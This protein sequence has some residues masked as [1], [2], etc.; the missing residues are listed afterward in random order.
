MEIILFSKFL[1]DHNTE[2]LIKRAQELGIEGY[3]LC[4]RP[5]HL[6][7]PD[8]ADKKLP[9]LTRALAG[10]GLS[11]P[12]V[13]GNFDL[14]TPDHPTA[15]PILSAMDKAD[16]R[17]LK[18]GY[19]KIDPEKEKYWDKVKEIRDIL[20]QWESL[21]Q[22]YNV[23]ICYHTHS[24]ENFMGL[25]CSALMHLLKDLNS[26]YIGAYIDPGHMLIDGEPLSLGLAMVKKYLSIVAVKDPYIYREE[27]ENEIDLKQGKA[28]REFRQ[29]GQGMVPWVEVM[30]EL[31]RIN[32]EG[33]LSVHGEYEISERKEYLKSLKSEVA[34][35]KKVRDYVMSNNI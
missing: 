16:I 4:V 21:A 8:N 25:N 20:K 6:V 32:Y 5:G 17:L 3:D 2:D 26:D 35:F 11:I 24:G 13:T 15:E 27:V 9:E 29:A 14:L 7:N 34:Y 1:K 18:P 12:M 23:K 30:K 31:K 10:E 22:K 19:F 33:P 28:E